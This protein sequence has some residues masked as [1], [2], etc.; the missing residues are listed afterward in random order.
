MQ[1]TYVL[2]NLCHIL[3]IGFVWMMLMFSYNYL[4]IYLEEYG[5][6]YEDLMLYMLLIMSKFIIEFIIEIYRILIKQK[7]LNIFVSLQHR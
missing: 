3:L 4:F 5:R 7:C 2:H 1:E 6:K